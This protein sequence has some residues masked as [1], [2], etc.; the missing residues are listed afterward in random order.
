MRVHDAVGQ[1]R[2]AE[3][4]G[5]ALDEIGAVDVAHDERRPALRAREE[6]HAIDHA[7]LLSGEHDRIAA[8]SA[9]LTP[10]WISLHTMRARRHALVERRTPADENP[11]GPS[12]VTE[13]E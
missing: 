13:E 10:V 12:R 6:L 7:R 8:V 4:G 11:G 5:Q 9:A 3:A 1:Q 2:L